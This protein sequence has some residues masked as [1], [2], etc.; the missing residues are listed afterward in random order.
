[1]AWTF[2]CE[3]TLDKSLPCSGPIFLICKV[4]GLNQISASQSVIHGPAA[5]VSPGNLLEMPIIRLNSRPSESDTLGM[6]PRNVCFIKPSRQREPK[7][8]QL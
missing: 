3:V 1:M 5:A 8:F 4:V 2:A 6:G 7:P